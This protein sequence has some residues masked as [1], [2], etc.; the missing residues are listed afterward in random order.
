MDF[1]Q[2]KTMK[3]SCIYLVAAA[4]TL[5]A[6]DNNYHSGEHGL[7]VSLS[8]EN[9]DD[10]PS[11]IADI[12]VYIYDSQDSKTLQ[13]DFATPQKLASDIFDVS[14]GNYTVGVFTNHGSQYQAS[15]IPAHLTLIGNTSNPANAYYGAN[16]ATVPSLGLAYTNIALRRVTSALTVKVSDLPSAATL[17]VEV[18]NAAIGIYP[19]V[20]N[21]ETAGYGIAD[22]ASTTALLPTASGSAT[23]TSSGT[24]MPTVA[25]STNSVLHITVTLADGTTLT[26]N[27]VAPKMYPSGN[28]IFEVKYSELSS[29]LILSTIRINNWTD[30]WVI[31]GEIPDYDNVI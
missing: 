5:S 18:A 8:L 20:Y 4:L 24:L 9:T 13:R 22:N 17:T 27:A 16:T 23:I 21:E 6:C 10:D 29:D 1:Q 30:G 11:T 15:G 14:A 31:N 7:A 26:T 25:S 3:H 19:F 2:T 28:Y 12:S